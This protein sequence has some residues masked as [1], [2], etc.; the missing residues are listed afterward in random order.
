MTALLEIDSES[1]FELQ[2]DELAKAKLD[3]VNVRFDQYWWELPL[4]EFESSS[5]KAGDI[6]SV[7]AGILCQFSTSASFVDFLVDSNTAIRPLGALN[8]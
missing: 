3:S 7:R 2:F 5:V 8:D 4:S 1:T 6:D